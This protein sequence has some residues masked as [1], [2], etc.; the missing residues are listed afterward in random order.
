MVFC[1]RNCSDLLTVRKNR[2][3]LAENLQKKFQSLEQFIQTLKD[4]NNV[5]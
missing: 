5:W 1:Y 2:S 4:Q 3:S